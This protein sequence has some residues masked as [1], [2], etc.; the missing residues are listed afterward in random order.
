MNK[1]IFDGEEY[2]ETL[3]MKAERIFEKVLDLIETKGVES[4]DEQ[5]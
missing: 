1:N 5:S 3:K 4:D 2:Y